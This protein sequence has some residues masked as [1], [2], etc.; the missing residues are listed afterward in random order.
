MNLNGREPSAQVD[1][2][3]QVKSNI[4]FR[5]NTIENMQQLNPG[6]QNMGLYHATIEISPAG[7]GPVTARINVIK[8][9]A[10]VDIM[11][12]NS[13]VSEIVKSH[14]AELREQFAQSDM[15]IDNI[16]VQYSNQKQQEYDH[17]ASREFNEDAGDIKTNTSSNKLKNSEKNR[18]NEDALIDTYI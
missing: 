17:Q 10:T 4:T 2:N 7:L 14:L 15:Q 18:V 8:G 3:N 5:I 13:H 1:I 6:N 12:K 16:N 11:V 9:R